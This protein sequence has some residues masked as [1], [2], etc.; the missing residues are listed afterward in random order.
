MATVRVM[1]ESLSGIRISSPIFTERD[2]GRE[3]WMCGLEKYLVF[4]TPLMKNSLLV[5]LRLMITSLE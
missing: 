3:D 4:S 2:W 5:Y 1:G